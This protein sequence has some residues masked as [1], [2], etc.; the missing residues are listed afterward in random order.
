ME[1]FN[2]R[3]SE[4]HLYSVICWQNDV[5]KR[6][7]SIKFCALFLFFLLRILDVCLLIVFECV[8]VLFFTLMCESSADVHN[9]CILC[10]SWTPTNLFKFSTFFF[11]LSLCYDN[12]I[13]FLKK[14]FYSF[15]WTRL[16]FSFSS[17]FLYLLLFNSQLF[18]L[19]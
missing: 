5:S 8:C 10:V 11:F 2:N 13:L 9:N 18:A 1:D 19:Y 14:L 12:L 7:F 6:V 4:I 17:S 15:A 3:N 16:I